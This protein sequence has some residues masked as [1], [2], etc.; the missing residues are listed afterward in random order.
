MVKENLEQ[1][2]RQGLGQMQIELD[3]RQV[4]RL[5]DYVSLL[6]QWNQAYN[7]TAVTAPEEMVRRHILDSLAILPYLRG[8]RFIDVGTGPGLPGIPLAIAMPQRD[9]TLLDSN[10]KRTRFLFQA[11]TTL[12]L[13]NAKEVQERVQDYRSTEGFDGI[14]SRAFSSLA[15]MVERTNHLLGARGF[16]YAMKGR[17]S[18]KELSQLRKPYTVCALHKLVV[19]GLARE[20]HLIEIG[21][22]F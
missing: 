6:H 15:E 14:I 9:F 10:G 21:K 17:V 22:P 11:I 18:E 7:L 8:N 5:L 3:G 1:L 12:E 4:G 20:R 16:F 19:P 13:G 2:L